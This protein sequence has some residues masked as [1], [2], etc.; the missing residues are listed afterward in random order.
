[1]QS[2]A[3]AKEKNINYPEIQE[4]QLENGLQVLAVQD[5]RF[6]RAFLSLVFP[7]GK[8]FNPDDNFS[9]VSLAVEMMRSGTE[10]RSANEISHFIDR[11][12]IN[13]DS[14]VSMEHSFIGMTFLE[15]E[16]ES[17]VALLADIVLKSTFPEDEL[18]KI[19]VRWQ[20][21]LIAQRSQPDFLA[22]ERLFKT[23]YANH[24]YSKISIT[25]EHLTG[26]TQKVIE[27][28]YRS[29]FSPRDAFL[30]FAGPVDL[31]T[32]T[33]LGNHFLGEWG[34]KEILPIQYPKPS[35]I[36]SRLIC[37]IHRPHSVQ[38]QLLVAGRALPK[39]NPDYIALKVVNQV[40]G[41]GA[42]SRLFLNLREDKGYTYGA[43]SRLKSYRSDGLFLAGAS[44]KTEVTLQCVEEILKEINQLHTAPPKKDEL[45][46]CQQELIG[47]FIRQME[48]SASVG[49]VELNRRIHGLPKNFYSTFIPKIR[50]IGED[51]AL[52]IAQRFF[53]PEKLVVTVVADRNKVESKL[54][55]M[56]ELH[57]YDTE[58]N[59]L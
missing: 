8:I 29:H 43:Y 37:L 13:Y 30:L 10:S 53:D 6:P 45:A 15:K 59:L 56:G 11:L 5:D 31:G 54:A 57:V 49:T 51:T 35:A 50:D 20:S 16:L 44:V 47:G 55:Q 22:N 7:V 24:P 27:T 41:G 26:V 9:L 33:N 12:A 38:S 25:S 52:E 28:F 48:T 14:D 36:D 21:H 1:M 17:A 58:G 42:N 46:R 34:N 2:P 39:D 32:A 18:E 23:L 19:R 3:P 4:S 40:L